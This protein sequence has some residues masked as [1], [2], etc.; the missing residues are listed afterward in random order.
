MP[1]PSSVIASTASPSRRA[2]SIETCGAAVLERVRE[3]LAEDERER[4]RALAGELDPLELG[5]DLLPADEPLDEHRPQP[6]EQ[7]GEVDVLVPLLGQLLVDGGDR[8]DPVDGVAERLPGS[9]PSARACSR[10]SEA[11]VCRLFL[12]R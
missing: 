1:A 2:E 10:R 4:R 11:T 8:E 9:T 3:Q 7:L 12:T 5:R 6:V